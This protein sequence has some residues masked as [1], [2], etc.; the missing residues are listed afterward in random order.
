MRKVK[1]KRSSEVK[2][3]REETCFTDSLYLWNV[4][5]WRAKAQQNAIK[6]VG[7]GH[8]CKYI[9]MHFCPSS[10]RWP[11]Y[12]NVRRKKTKKQRQQPIREIRF[13]S[14]ED[15]VRRRMER[16]REQGEDGMLP[17]WLW[18]TEE[19]T[20]SLT[21]LSIEYRGKKFHSNY[22]RFDKNLKNVANVKL[23]DKYQFQ[24][25]ILD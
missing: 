19:K 15:T 23:L 6:T 16:Q 12:T 1:S 4:S 10:C 13:L 11:V 3:V 25:Q 8:L 5:G 24:F 14:L 2:S 21:K 9:H 18:K 22:D 7:I 20:W 17:D